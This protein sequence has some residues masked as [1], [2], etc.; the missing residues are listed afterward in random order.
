MLLPCSETSRSFEEETCTHIDL[1]PAILFSGGKKHI[2]EEGTQFNIM[3]MQNYVP[4]Q[5]SAHLFYIYIYREG[6]ENHAT[7]CQE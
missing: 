1:C 5:I 3:H 2:A 7:S 4:T 6:L